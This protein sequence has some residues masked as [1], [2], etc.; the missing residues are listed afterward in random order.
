ML[1][2][3]SKPDPSDRLDSMSHKVKQSV[4]SQNAVFQN[5]GSNEYPSAMLLR[6]LLKTE[7]KVPGDPLP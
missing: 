6:V 4:E 7:L 3:W 1:R 5:I 2:K